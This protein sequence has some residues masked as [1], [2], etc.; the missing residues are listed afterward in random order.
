MIETKK[1]KRSVVTDDIVLV[2]SLLESI[3]LFHFLKNHFVF[4]LCAQA[5]LRRKAKV[6]RIL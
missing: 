4:C 2:N 1:S 5:R 3:A 6:M